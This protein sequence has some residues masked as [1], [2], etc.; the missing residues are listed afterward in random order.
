MRRRQRSSLAQPAKTD[1]SERHGPVQP[2]DVIL[3]DGTT[4]RLRPPT[5][6]DAE[7]LVALFGGL[8]PESLYRRFHR[9]PTV[10]RRLVEPVLDPDWAETGALVGTV[11]GDGAERAV[12]LASYA[13]LRDPSAAEVAFT[14]ADDF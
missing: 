1:S 7:R 10:D 2:V 6:A 3:R 13:R 14:V 4:L 11:A 12:A 8:S 9:F 5:S